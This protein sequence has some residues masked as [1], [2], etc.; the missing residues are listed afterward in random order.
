MPAT[1]WEVQLLIII[2][3]KGIPQSSFRVGGGGGGGVGAPSD[4]NDCC[5]V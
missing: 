5:H 4:V 3:Y 2:F 1:G